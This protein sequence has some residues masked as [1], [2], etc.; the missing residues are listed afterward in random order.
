MIHTFERRRIDANRLYG[1]IVSESD[2]LILVQREY[3]FEFDGYIVIRRQDF[4]KSYSSDSN[5]YCE[6]LMHKEG[7]WKRPTKSIR[8]LPLT[9]WRSMLTALSG[10]TVII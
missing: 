10:N 3:D 2:F 1:L 7:P 4:S 6:R 8:S 5:S 9:D